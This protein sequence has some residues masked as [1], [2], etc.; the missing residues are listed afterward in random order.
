MANIPT[1][2]EDTEKTLAV[3]FTD[4]AF[5]LVFLNSAEVNV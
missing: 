4:I 5:L 1:R 2:S 3:E